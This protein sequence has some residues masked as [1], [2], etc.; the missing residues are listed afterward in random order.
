MSVWN[1]TRMPR[2]R[3]SAISMT[4]NPS[5]YDRL[6]I[7]FLKRLRSTASTTS[8]PPQ[9]LQGGLLKRRNINKC[10]TTLFL[11]IA[12]CRSTLF[13]NNLS[14]HRII[15]CSSCNQT[16]N[17]MNKT[18]RLTWTGSLPSSKINRWG[19]TTKSLKIE[20]WFAT[21]L[22]NRRMK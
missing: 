17:N 2:R 16:S 13:P 4:R 18:A 5:I 22:K 15:T 8:K 14:K 11:W 9:G 19:S 10:K 1:W 6:W 7:P 20:S 12:W 21:P 3:T